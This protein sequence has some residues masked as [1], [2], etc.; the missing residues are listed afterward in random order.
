[1]PKKHLQRIRTS[2]RVTAAWLAVFTLAGAEHRGVV[3]FGR[4]PV[5]G[6]TVTASQGEKKLATT[7]DEQGVYRFA[8][9]SDGTWTIQVEMPCFAPI[10]EDVRIVPNAPSPEWQLRMLA[11]PDLLNNA[12]PSASAPRTAATG[13]Q[14]T[15]LKESLM[16][17]AVSGE[18]ATPDQDQTA[19]D[20]LLINGSVNNGAASPFAQSM[21]FGNNRRGLRGRYNGA[22]GV[23]LD[24]SALDA[25]SFSLTGQNTPKAAY[26]HLQGTASLGGPLRIPHLWGTSAA[27]FFAGYQMTRSRLASTQSAL[28]PLPAERDGDFSRVL[29]SLGQ[30]VQIY[31]PLTGAP[32]LDNAIPRQ[33]ISP[34]ALALLKFYPMP[35][36]AAGVRYNYQV[37]VT[38]TQDQDNVQTR[39]NKTFGFRNQAN[40]S[41]N[42]QRSEGDNTNL[43]SLTDRTQTSGIDVNANWQHRF[44][45]RVFARLGYSFNR[46]S[47]RVTPHFANRENVSGEAGVMGNNQEPLNWGPPGLASSLVIRAG[48]GVTRDTSVYSSIAN[49]M[50]QQSPLS[51]SLS[52]QNTAADP[53][54]LANGFNASPTIT[55]NTFAVDP[56]FRAG[57]AQSWNFS[58][59]HE[60]PGALIMNVNY[61]GIK[62]A[63]AQQQ[64]LPNTYPA[65]AVNPCPACPAGFAYLTSN[66]NSTREAG[67]IQLRRRLHSGFA[68]T[69]QYTF[70]KSIDDAA[71]GGRGRSAALMA[72]DWLDLRAERALSNFDQRHLV[73]VQMQYSTGMGVRGAGLLG[74]VRGGLFKDWTFTSQINAG[75]GLPL[76]PVYITAVRGT[77]VTGSVRPDYTGAPLYAA[78]AGLALNPAAY[79]GPGPGHW[80]NAGRNTITGPSRFSLN[81]SLGRTFRLSDRL[82]SD[83]RLDSMNALNHVTYLSWSTNIS[84]AQFGLPTAANAM[85]T[86]QATFRVRF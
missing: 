75:S 76:T 46:L 12:R 47:S 67:Q 20:G 28:M 53:L 59:Q 33:R 10:Q 83:L 62:G 29:N 81:A 50:A 8:D 63:R 11:A 78:P 17:V 57:Y 21:A 25:R 34:Q 37:P 23:A 39:L 24:N 55:P 44:A 35:N 2:S 86:M 64:F 27:N 3:K 58:L 26:N 32:F 15:D 13:F 68:A 31:D 48:Y 73:N 82:S 30:P 4:V 19:A 16:A 42:W 49:L 66:G 74:G 65:G 69:V 18:T 60:L 38:G 1:M 72:Q 80:G 36:F 14:H 77:G 43:F 51:K 79:A 9:L 84:S 40:G 45:T 71:L 70:S 56:N 54:T 61:L 85:R 52:V 5:P 6:A 7:S 41:L 22:L